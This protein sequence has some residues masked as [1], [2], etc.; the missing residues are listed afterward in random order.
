MVFEVGQVKGVQIKKCA[1]AFFS[2]MFSVVKASL[3]WQV[4]TVFNVKKL[5]Y[6]H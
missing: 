5:Q 4:L 3:Q 6:T 2:E 1:L